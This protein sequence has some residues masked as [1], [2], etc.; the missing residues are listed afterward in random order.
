MGN[1]FFSSKQNQLL[2]T[3]VM[4][5]AI[6]ALGAYAYQTLTKDDNFGMGPTSIN[7]VGTGEVV[8]VPDIAQ[9]SFSVRGEGADAAIAQEA[10]G[11]VINAVMAYLKESAVEERD[12]KT[13]GYNMYPKYR[14]ED[15]PCPFGSYCPG[16]G[17]Q[18]ADGFEVTQTITVK[19]RATDKAGA[20]LAG[21][22]ELGATD[23]S[24][25]TFTTDN[26][27]AL[28]DEARTLAIAD[29]KAKAEKLADDLGVELVKMIGYY[30]DMPYAP[31]PYYAMEADMSVKS[32][33]GFAGPETPMGEG[34]ITSTVNLTYEIE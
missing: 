18:I 9:F 17:E 8:A 6:A 28:K 16:S 11:S 12:I 19:V 2:G 32:E 3:L 31:S 30:E 13:E 29:A 20:L 27:E 4:V 14:Y 23:I 1:S 26:P 5:A 10:S 21:V 33:S 34:T 24:G 25:L 15:R 22:G 7:I